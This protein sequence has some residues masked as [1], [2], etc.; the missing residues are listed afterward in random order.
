MRLRFLSAGESHGQRICVIVEGLPAGLAVNPDEINRELSRRQGGYGRGGR[1]EIEKDRALIVSGVR[2]GVTT[3][4]PVSVEIENLDYKNWADVMAVEE[5]REKAKPVTRPRPG[6]VDLAGMLKTASMD[7][8]D[9]ME[10]ASARETASRVAAG[11]IAKLLLSEIGVRVMGMVVQIGSVKVSGGEAELHSFE[12]AFSDPLLC[13]DPAVSKNMMEE[14][15]SAREDGDTLG[16]VFEVAAFGVV[17]GLGSHT[18]WDRR[19]DGK[20]ACALMSIPGIKGVEIGGGFSLSASKGSSVHD[21]IILREDECIGRRTNR[22]GGIEAG[23]TNGETIL[24]R[25]AMKPIPTLQKPLKT[26]DLATMK[27]ASASVERSD[28][29]AVPSACVIGEAVVALTLADAALEKFGGDSLKEF[30]RNYEGYVEQIS[31]F[32]KIER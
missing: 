29:C 19:L 10:R 15:D 14:I 16:G 1:M 32:W 7:A 18:Q 22:A 13:C 17:P 25:A 31:R 2:Y 30:K 26:V 9:V 3:G 5:P 28:I 20:L 27:E 4:A 11:S 24:V 21:E 8:R 6:H 12:R 23:I